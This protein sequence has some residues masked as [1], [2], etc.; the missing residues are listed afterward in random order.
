M[1]KM[2]L[3]VYRT[4]PDGRT[5]TIIGYCDNYGQVDAMLYEDRDKIDWEAHY[6]IEPDVKTG[7]SDY[8]E[9]ENE[10]KTNYS[11]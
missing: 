5:K 10:N 6:L 7:V 4:E 3:T 8:L 9:G 11:D 1:Y 2:A